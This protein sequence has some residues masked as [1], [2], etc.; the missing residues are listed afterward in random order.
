MMM[1]ML[2]VIMMC[3]I[4]AKQFHL[5]GDHLRYL[6]AGGALAAIPIY[7]VSQRVIK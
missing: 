4:I 5:S 1:V 3:A 2:I 7:V 6:M